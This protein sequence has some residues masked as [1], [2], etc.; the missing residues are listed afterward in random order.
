MGERTE[1]FE[2][3]L[4]HWTRGLSVYKTRSF[5]GWDISNSCHN[6]NLGSNI[7]ENDY[8]YLVQADMEK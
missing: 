6:N 2:G 5:E 3:G 7:W 8:W 1:W 4:A